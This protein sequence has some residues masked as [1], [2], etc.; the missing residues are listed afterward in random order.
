MCYDDSPCEMEGQAAPGFV[1][2]DT[3][4]MFCGGDYA[5]A[6]ACGSPCPS[7]SDGKPSAALRNESLASPRSFM[8][9]LTLFDI[10]AHRVSR[11]SWWADVLG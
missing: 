5:A 9:H 7:G 8:T 1:R 11:L 6:T 4:K 3:S 10:F 2:R